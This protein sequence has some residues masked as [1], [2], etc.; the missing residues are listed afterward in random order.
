[1]PPEVTL[2]STCHP[3]VLSTAAVRT[4][5]ACQ[6]VRAD[7][8]IVLKNLFYSFGYDPQLDKVIRFNLTDVIA[9]NPSSLISTLSFTARTLEVNSADNKPATVD[10]VTKTFG[11]FNVAGAL[12]SV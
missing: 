5:V 7:S 12:E 9:K 3:V 2:S 4:N 8:K 1:M 6:I 10:E 11:A